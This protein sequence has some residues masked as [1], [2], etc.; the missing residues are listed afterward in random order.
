MFYLFKNQYIRTSMRRQFTL[1][2]G[3]F[4]L[5]CLGGA[6][7]ARAQNVGIGT[8]APTT[9]LHVDGETRVGSTGL[10]AAAAGAGALRW[11]GTNLQYSDGTAWVTL[12]DAFNWRLNGNAGTVPGTGVGQNYLGTSDAQDLVVATNGT[13]RFRIYN[14]YPPSSFLTRY[15]FEDG[16][17]RIKGTNAVPSG[18]MYFQDSNNRG[19]TGLET[20]AGGE[21]QWVIYSA[22]TGTSFFTARLDN[23][24]VGIGTLNPGT[25]LHVVSNANVF[26]MEGS[27]H[28]YL[29]FYPD[30]P[31]TRKGFFG[32]P[33]PTND[34]IHLENEI[35]GR[36]I[37]LEGSGDGFVG[38]GGTPAAKLDVFD[39][40]RMREGGNGSAGTWFHNGGADRFF[41]GNINNEYLGIYG[42]GLN[43]WFVD[44]ERTQGRTRMRTNTSNLG[45]HNAAHLEIRNN[46]VGHAVISFHNEGVWGAHLGLEMIQHSD[47]NMRGALTTRGW[48]GDSW[49]GHTSLRVGEVVWGISGSNTLTRTFAGQL[50]NQGARSGFFEFNQTSGNSQDYQYPAGYAGNT[51]WHLIDTR[52]QNPDNN[53]AMQIAG[54]F[55]DQ[56]LFFRK[57]INDAN[58]PWREIVTQPI[59]GKIIQT[60]R[61][62]GLGNDPTFNT[63]YAV[64]DW[65]AAIAGFNTGSFDYLENCCGELSVY[66]ANIGGFWHIISRV[67]NHNA[68]APNWTAFVQFTS[69]SYCDSN[70]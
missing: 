23:M 2:V 31:A 37:I 10:T 43:N 6:T 62:T 67:R 42:V 33:A 34:D 18:I 61:F 4:G 45:V 7:T 20:G 8:A 64:S 27:D 40:M 15:D 32:F 51:W 19:Y 39:R 46:G 12:A 41:I 68:P 44:F 1:R 53:F 60:R 48:S 38:V 47:G 70:Y 11:N 14:T 22:S 49:L 54:N 66:M 9:R 30:G 24:R 25:R 52:H 58:Q 5:L 21:N 28:A 63:G 29:E 3:L 50:G 59:S 56:R 69:K 36:H 13:Q 35:A 55:F 65:C 26:R 16:R 57:T 17:V